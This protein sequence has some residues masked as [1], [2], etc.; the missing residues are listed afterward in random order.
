[1]PKLTNIP[2]EAWVSLLWSQYNRLS[3]PMK[4]GFIK[5]TQGLEKE[6]KGQDIECQNLIVKEQE[7]SIEDN[8]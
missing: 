1:M 2:S 7:F 5:L 3:E 8:Q 6:V 4:E